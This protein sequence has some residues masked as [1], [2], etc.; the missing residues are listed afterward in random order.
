MD[1]SEMLA[2]ATT[3]AQTTRTQVLAALR[4]A[5]AE[6]GSDFSYLLGTAMR[7]SSLKPQAK[8]EGSSATG[9][10]QFVSQTW[11][12]MIK[13][14]GAKYGLGSYADAIHQT[15]GGRYEADNPADRQAILALRNDPKVSALMAG[16]YANQTKSVLENRLGRDV[17]GGELYAAHFMGAGA[18]CRL[19]EMN[20]S[21]PGANA[22][23]CFPD[24][25]GANRSVFYNADGSSKTVGEVY[26]WAMKQPQVS[27]RVLAQAE[28]VK[29]APQG[30]PAAIPLSFA[31]SMFAQPSRDDAKDLSTI[32]LFGDAKRD[33]VASSMSSLLPQ[34]ALNLTS[35][36]VNMLASMSP[37]GRTHSSEGKAFG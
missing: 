36:I 22:A 14:Y 2:E 34:T 24:A 18:A 29:A 4:Q 19:I 11:L 15:S 31:S 8:A 1:P 7:E 13:Q 33:T 20:N 32:G 21:N 3:T 6:T 5:S 37:D 25:A 12:G 23:S 10:F 9:L 16:E 17:C 26:Q 28:T 27:P 30:T 35:G